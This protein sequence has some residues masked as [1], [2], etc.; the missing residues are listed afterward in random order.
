[1]KNRSLTPTALDG[2]TEFASLIVAGREK[3]TPMKEKETSVGGGDTH[4]VA[5]L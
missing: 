2:A 4:L 1:M 5:F 3:D